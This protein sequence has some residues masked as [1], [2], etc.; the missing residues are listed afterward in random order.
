MPEPI[1]LLL[2]KL[3]PDTAA[4]IANKEEITKDADRGVLS[5]S[6]KAL[7]KKAKV[8]LENYLAEINRV[9]SKFPD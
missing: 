1:K 5:G 7:L 3:D 9:L 6:S 8:K 4:Y 2:Q